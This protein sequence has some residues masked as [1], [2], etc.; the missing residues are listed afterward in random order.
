[1]ARIPDKETYQRAWSQMSFRQRREI[2]RAVGRGQP[3][4]RRKDAR[5]AVATARNQ[6]RYWKFAWLMAPAVALVALPD[7]AAVAVQAVLLTT[8][9][10]GF[11]W[12]RIRR[13]R[14]AEEANIARLDG[15]TAVPPKPA[16]VTAA[17]NPFERA[18]NW[19]R[20]LV[21]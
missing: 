14:Q 17:S 4:R 19:V 18:R 10:G 21:G 11:A 13:A 16:T 5:L 7:W 1:M 8:I 3:M 20:S 2:L 9:M 15:T 12:H 6:Q